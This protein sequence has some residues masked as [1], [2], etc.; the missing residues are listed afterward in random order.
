MIAAAKMRRFTRE[1]YE[2]LVENGFFGPE[3]R[4]EL[5]EGYIYEKFPLTGWHAAG[6]QALQEILVPIFKEGYSIRFRMPLALGEESEPE[7]DVAVVQ[8][9]WREYRNAHPCT[10]L[11]VAEVTDTT[12]LHDRNRKGTLYAMANIPDYWILNRHDQY[13]EVLRD[14]RDGR[15]QSRTTLVAGDKVSPLAKPGVSISVSNLL[16]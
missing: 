1:E 15:Y 7:P 2:H 14:P 16:F 4:V 10:A 12:L 5:L 13:L 9:H 6:I 11:L 8:G 3:E